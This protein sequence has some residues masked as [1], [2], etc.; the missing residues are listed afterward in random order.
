MFLFLNDV[1]IKHLSKYIEYF[2]SLHFPGG[3]LSTCNTNS[4]GYIG[5]MNY[6]I[7]FMLNLSTIYQ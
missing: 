2:K 4:I 1:L 6:I 3:W 7:N 5:C